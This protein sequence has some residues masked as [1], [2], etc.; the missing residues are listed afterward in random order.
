MARI[1]GVNIPTNKRACIALTY[2][3]GIG[4]KIA[5]DICEKAS[6]D[7]SKRINELTEDEISKIRELI[8]K[9][10]DGLNSKK[11]KVNNKKVKSSYKLTEYL[12]LV[13]L[14]TPP[15]IPLIRTSKPNLFFF[16]S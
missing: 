16:K 14:L 12:E 3:F 1:S 7:K 11:I 6:I 2:I 9:N 13:D 4:S 15:G 8:D 10:Y 5:S